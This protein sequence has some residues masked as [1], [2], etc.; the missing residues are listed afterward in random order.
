VSAPGQ[1][2]KGIYVQAGCCIPNRLSVNG[3]E[4]AQGDQ[5]LLPEV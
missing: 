4:G 3:Y 5:H 2:R 1:F